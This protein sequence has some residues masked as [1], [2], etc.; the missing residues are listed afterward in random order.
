MT[1]MKAEEENPT[2]IFEENRNKSWSSK[3]KKKEID[4][5]DNMRVT[6]RTEAMVNY[7]EGHNITMKDHKIKNL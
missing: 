2:E 3:K 7:Q 5:L 6:I 1:M 4:S